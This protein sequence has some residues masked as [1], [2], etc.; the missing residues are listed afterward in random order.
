LQTKLRVERKERQRKSSVDA[1]S[2]S[3]RARRVVQT[4]FLL[5]GTES[6]ILR[7]THDDSL[8][9]PKFDLS[10]MSTALPPEKLL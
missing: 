10:S 3:K 2:P 1:K 5:A 4:L 8:F 6:V 9:G 7:K